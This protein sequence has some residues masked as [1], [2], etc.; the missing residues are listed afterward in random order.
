MQV[1]RNCIFAQS[2]RIGFY[3]RTRVASSKEVGLHRAFGVPHTLDL[4]GI[5]H[6]TDLLK[7]VVGEAELAGVDALLDACRVGL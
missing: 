6:V 5:N 3:N 7:L 2:F 4:E 1:I